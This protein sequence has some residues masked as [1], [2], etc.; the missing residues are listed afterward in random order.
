ME[1]LERP[2]QC[3]VLSKS[4]KQNRVT[5]MY[6]KF[7]TFSPH[8]SY[9]LITFITQ[10]MMTSNLSRTYELYWGNQIINVES[11]AEKLG[12]NSDNTKPT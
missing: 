9:Q 4:I 10:Y 2:N 7:H 6:H 11:G 3:N 1:K 8:K 12:L 5:T